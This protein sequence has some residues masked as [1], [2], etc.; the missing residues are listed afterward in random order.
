[1]PWMG[2]GSLSAL[3]TSRGRDRKTGPRL[4]LKAVTSALR[5][6]D[7]AGPGRE[8]MVAILVTG[9]TSATASKPEGEPSCSAPRPNAERGTSPAMCTTGIPS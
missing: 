5:S 8:I 2:W 6:T 4:P 7:A 1:M 3:A 9:R